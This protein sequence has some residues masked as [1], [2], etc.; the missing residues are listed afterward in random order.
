MCKC[1]WYSPGTGV[2]PLGRSVGNTVIRWHRSL[3]KKKSYMKEDNGGN[4]GGW[5]S[6]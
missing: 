3:K 4:L 6:G 5:L 2:L 1:V